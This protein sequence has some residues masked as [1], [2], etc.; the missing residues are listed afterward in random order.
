MSTRTTSR[1]LA[2]TVALVAVASI[3]ACS[4][5]TEPDRPAEPTGSVQV[6]LEATGSEGGIY[7]LA[8]TFVISD[9]YTDPV[10]VSEDDSAPNV[11]LVPRV[12]DYDLELCG[13]V[14]GPPCA[15]DAPNAAPWQIFKVECVDLVT[16]APLPYADCQA[17]NPG[18]GEQTTPVADAELDGANPRAVSVLLNQITSVT[19]QFYLPGEGT[20]VFA[21]GE[22]AIDIAVGEGFP[23]GHSCFDP[24]GIECQSHVCNIVGQAQFP[25]CIP[26]TCDDGVLNGDEDGADCGGPSCSV[27]CVGSP[28]TADADCGVA[29]FC[30]TQTSACVQRT[31]CSSD[32]ECVGA[33]GSFAEVCEPTNGFCV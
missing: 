9:F 3:G 7:R 18:A 28:C 12:G 4:A 14:Q 29:G 10:T 31:S 25:E 30:D 22:V 1:R 11:T 27:T 5:P 33:P 32:A 16:L 23:D 13:A 17:G 20:V 19:Y 24:S 8:G 21:T 26:A 6:E 2:S 15:N